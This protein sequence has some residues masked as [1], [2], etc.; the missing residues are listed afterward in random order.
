MI[1]LETALAKLPAAAASQQEAVRDAIER[2]TAT[3]GRHVLYYLGPP[4]ERVE[5]YDGD[6][7]DIHLEEIPT[8]DTDLSVETRD[9]MFSDWEA[10]DELDDDAKPNYVLDGRTLVHRTGWPTGRKTV[11]VTYVAGWDEGEGPI[12][13]QTLVLAMVVAG[14]NEDTAAAAIAGGLKSERIG[15]YQY[16]NFTAAEL[17]AAASAAAGSSWEDVAK[18]WRRRL[19]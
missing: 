7:T 16:E 10:L 8:P 11:R 12:H 13:F 17:E 18:Q 4:L 6:G 1:A 3:L 14:W 19:I 15:D 5:T 2:A 9:D